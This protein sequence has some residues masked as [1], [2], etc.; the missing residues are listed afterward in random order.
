MIMAQQWV[1]LLDFDGTITEYDADY[2]LADAALGKKAKD[3]Y[4]PLARAYENLEIGTLQYFEGYLKG[5]ALTPEQIDTHIKSV[6]VRNGF[7]FLLESC[8]DADVPVTIVSEGLDVYI[9][10]ILRE[11]GVDSYDLSCNRAIYN[12][13]KFEVK[14]ARDAEPCE[15]C[16]NCKGPHVLRWKAAGKKVALIGNGASDLCGAQKADLVIA[17]DTLLEHCCRKGIPHE[18]WKSLEQ[19]WEILKRKV[20]NHP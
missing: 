8:R 18:K 20:L 9:E 2:A 10:P 5:L 19:A 17:R 3:I 12:G 6:E 15:R 16:L 14:P 13:G 1:L 11:E 4:G 7:R